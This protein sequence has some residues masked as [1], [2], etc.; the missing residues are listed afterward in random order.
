MQLLHSLKCIHLEWR[1]L[2]GPFRY[3]LIQTVRLNLSKL[4]ASLMR[5]YFPKRPSGA[6]LHTLSKLYDV[7]VGFVTPPLFWGCVL[8]YLRSRKGGCCSIL[9]DLSCSLIWPIY[10]HRYLTLKN[11]TQRIWSSFVPVMVSV[12]GEKEGIPLPSRDM[13]EIPLKRRKAHSPVMCEIEI[14][15]CRKIN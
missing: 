7:P 6:P 11:R 2:F 12:E 14:S 1:W 5:N 10:K 3:M 9:D 15:N 4:L 8:L 13:A